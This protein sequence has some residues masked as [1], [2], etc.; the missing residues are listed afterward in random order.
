[1][2][3]QGEAYSTRA[4]VLTGKQATAIET[5]LPRARVVKVPDA[6]YLVFESHEMLVLREIRTFVPSLK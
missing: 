1:M 4:T 2:R 3:A 5:R 6:G